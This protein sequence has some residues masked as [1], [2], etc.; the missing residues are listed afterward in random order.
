MKMQHLGEEPREAAAG[1]E[2]VVA[3]LGQRRNGE[4]EIG[5]GKPPEGFAHAVGEG[6]RRLLRRS[7]PGRASAR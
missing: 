2:D 3:R 6:S 4:F 7:V 5:D 1:D